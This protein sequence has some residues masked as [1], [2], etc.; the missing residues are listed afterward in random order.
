MKLKW[1]L[2]RNTQ[3]DNQKRVDKLY[4][5]E[6]VLCG[7]LIVNWAFEDFRYDE[8]LFSLDADSVISK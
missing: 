2:T 3:W 5:D 1:R 4:A 8:G 6:C 7:S